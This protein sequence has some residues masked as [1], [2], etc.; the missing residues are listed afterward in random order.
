MIEDVPPH[1]TLTNLL[2]TAGTIRETSVC[3]VREYLVGVGG[4]G[5]GGGSLMGY[6]AID[7]VFNIFLCVCVCVNT[8]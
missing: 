5:G 2:I 4:G 6:L 7:L 8:K 3:L 1:C